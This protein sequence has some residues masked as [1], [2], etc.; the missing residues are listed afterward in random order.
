[1]QSSP[2]VVQTK[3]ELELKYLDLLIKM[4]DGCIS[5]DQYYSRLNSRINKVC[6]NIEKDLA[7]K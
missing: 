3:L 6:D 5:A 7:L 1:M 4:K 2:I